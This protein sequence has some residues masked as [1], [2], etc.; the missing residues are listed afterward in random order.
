MLK[1]CPAICLYRP[2]LCPSEKIA[3]EYI[4]YYTGVIPGVKVNNSECFVELPSSHPGSAGAR[5]YILGADNPDS[6]RGMYLDG[7]VL[8]EYGQMKESIW[9]EI[10]RPALA[11]REGWAVFVGTPKGQNGFYKNGWKRRAMKVGIPYD[12]RRLRPDSSR[13]RS[14]KI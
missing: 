14:L 11:D 8:D 4:K 7:V 10:L 1:A 12:T 2:F 5:I 9:S 3:W 13:P 6:L